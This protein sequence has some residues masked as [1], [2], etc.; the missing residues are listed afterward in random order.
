[1]TADHGESLGEHGEDTH[2]IFLY[3]ATLRVPLILAGPGVPGGRVATTVAR[4]DRRA[5]HAPRLRR[6]CRRA[7]HGGPLAAAGRRRAS[8]SSDAPAYAESLHPQ[9]QYGWAPLHAWRTARYK[10]IE[11]PRPELYDLEEDAGET[12]RP[13]GERARRVV[14]AMRRSSRRAM[15]TTTPVA[16]RRRSTPRRRSGSRALG[17]LGG[18]R[19]R[20]APAPTARDPKDGIGLVTRLGRN[21]MSVARTE[22]EKAIRELTALLAEDPGMLVALPHARRGLRDRGPVRR[23]AIARPA[24]P[25][26]ARRAH[27]PRTR[28]CSATTCASP[29]DAT[30]ATAVLEA[31]GARRTRSSRSRWLSLAAVYI[32]AEQLAD[33]GGAPTRRCSSIEPDNIEALRGLGDL[34]LI[35][36]RR[37]A[38][39]AARYGRI[40]EVDPTDAGA[41]TKLGVVQDA[42]RGRADEAIAAVPA[43]RR[44]RAEE[45]RGAALPGGR[46]RGERPPG[47]GAAVLRARARRGAAHARWRSTASALTRLELGDRAGAAA[48]FRESLRL[49][50]NQP[51][52]AAHPR[53]ARPALSR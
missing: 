53:R 19:R 23:G 43:G 16:A 39:R 8:G 49:D 51:D 10:L 15:A 40:L 44:A 17:Y 47:G 21:G 33:G 3:D 29:A 52:V 42:R 22:P 1:M 34:A 30:E 37:R 31:H 14:E 38:R 13:R 27:A 28:S 2:G 20:S 24:R 25:R 12:R 45:R 5:A 50:P 41:L 18:G 32:Q 46:A 35:Q 7:T 36:R 6:P 4:G 26:E 48:A 11:A 9:L